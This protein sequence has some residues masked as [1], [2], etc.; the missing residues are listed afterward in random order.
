MSSGFSTAQVGRNW[1]T[2][3]VY[4]GSLE[5]PLACSHRVGMSSQKPRFIFSWN[6]GNSSLAKKK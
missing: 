2:D 4:Q 6:S 1:K 5:F 3:H